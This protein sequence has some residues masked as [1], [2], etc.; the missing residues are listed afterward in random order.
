M[1]RSSWSV[2]DDSQQQLVLLCEV[3]RVFDPI[4]NSLEEVFGDSPLPTDVPSFFSMI[5]AYT[6]LFSSLRAMKMFRHHTTRMLSSN[7]EEI[8]RLSFISDWLEQATMKLECFKE[9][10]EKL[11]DFWSSEASCPPAG[12]HRCF[13]LQYHLEEALID[14]TS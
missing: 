8:A 3:I 2:S 12:H 9:H 1:T 14:L 6:S 4:L 10:L 13:L 11:I 5:E 7:S